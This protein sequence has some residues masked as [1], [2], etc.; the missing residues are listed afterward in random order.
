M[1]SG[2]RAV[3]A[4]MAHWNG[5]APG[6]TACEQTVHCI[7]TVRS[8]AG[9]MYLEKYRYRFAAPHDLR[10]QRLMASCYMHV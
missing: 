9:M 10:C 2:Y 1:R 4:Q 6:P 3:R 8:F 5:A 7:I